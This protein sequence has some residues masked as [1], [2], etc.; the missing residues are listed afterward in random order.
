MRRAETTIAAE[1]K[2]KSRM[3]LQ[4][5]FFFVGLSSASAGCNDDSLESSGW[6]SSGD[7]RAVIGEGAD[8]RYH[9][10]GRTGHRRASEHEDEG[11]DETEGS[12]LTVSGWTCRRCPPFRW[13]TDN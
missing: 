5:S 2:R 6:G 4:V 13:E 1:L 11:K 3:A 8:A 10:F 9:I 12:H 7:R